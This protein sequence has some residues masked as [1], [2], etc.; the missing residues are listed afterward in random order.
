VT[1]DSI[2]QRDEQTDRGTDRQTNRNVMS[3]ALC[4]VRL[5]HLAEMLIKLICIKLA[6]KILM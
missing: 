4:M 1:L 5:S 3:I 6:T 2:P